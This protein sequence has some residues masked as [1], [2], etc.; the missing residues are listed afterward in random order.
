MKK[1]ASLTFLISTIAM[2]VVFVACPDPDPIND[3]G[4]GKVSA[5]SF[6][7]IDGQRVKSVGSNFR[8]SYD[9]KGNLSSY[10][11]Y[12]HRCDLSLNPFKLIYEYNDKY[13]SSRSV[14]ELKINRQGLISQITE[15][16][17]YES[18]YDFDISENGTATS[19]ITYNKNG[20][21]EKIEVKGSEKGTEKDGIETWDET[22][23]FSKTFTYT[24]S[25]SVLKRIK[26][27]STAIGVENGEKAKENKTENIEFIYDKEY[28]NTYF[29]Y[30]P[31]YVDYALGFSYELEGLAYIGMFGKASSMLPSRIER[32]RWY[33]GEEDGEDYEH[34]DYE[35][36]NCSYSF[37]ANGA[38]KSADGYDYTYTSVD[39]RAVVEDEPAEYVTVKPETRHRGISSRMM[40]HHG[41]KQ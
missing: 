24:Y 37:K 40:H 34:D 19:Y 23:D 32:T 21:I 26:S 8:C 2:S 41:R 35:Y 33:Y 18:T 31:Y 1:N 30:T 20:Q 25:G 15:K 7:D 10:Y 13:E 4:S 17:T 28:E 22:W 36:E 6:Y 38:I 3:G 16:Y 12:D 39:T 5:K 11:I 9:E 27:I 14:F 29:Q